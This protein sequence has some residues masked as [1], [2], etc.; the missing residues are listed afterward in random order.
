MSD[1]IP[2]SSNRLDSLSRRGPPAA[3]PG[4][5][6]KPKVVAR[7]TKEE[8]DADA[9]INEVETK[10]QP[11]IRGGSIRGRGSLRGGR[12]GNRNLI[13]TH[14]VQAGPL[15]SGNILSDTN[16]SHTR[17]S[18]RGSTPDY[19]SKLMNKSESG[20]RESSLGLESDDETDL[21]RIDM[22]KDYKFSNEDV[23]LFPV[24]APRLDNNNDDNYNNNNEETIKV[25]SRSISPETDGI[26]KEDTPVKEE[27][28][29]KSLTTLLD[30]KANDLQNKLND[31]QLQQDQDQ[32]HFGTIEDSFRLEKD[33]KSIL[34]TLIDINNQNDK[35]MF[36]QLPKVLPE[37]EIPEF[38]KIREEQ[39][40]NEEKQNGESNEEEIKKEK[41]IPI[42]IKEEDGKTK[43]DKIDDDLKI[44]KELKSN[45][46]QGNIGNLRIHKSGKLTMQIGNVIMD[47][48]RGSRT[49]FL[50]QIV[51][52]DKNTDDDRQNYLLGHLQDKVDVIPR[53]D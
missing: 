2:S 28:V 46:L 11:S 22:S 41:D 27:P 29:E 47:V 40:N 24:R 12:G 34:K 42:E 1:K 30:E 13:G 35:F 5:K 49:D 31:L 37:F 38:Q 52:V 50:Q 14:V 17:S 45:G 7:R 26:I 21:T 44:D 9:P 23:Q 16:D 51:L 25:E 53:F 32:D 6:F 15:A 8:R 39:E 33:H 36:I 20:T 18:T 4:M 43:I 10:K 3:K 48:G 19:L